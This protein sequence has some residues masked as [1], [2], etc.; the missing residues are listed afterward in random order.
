[1][2]RKLCKD[3]SLDYMLTLEK[4]SLLWLTT[5]IYHPFRISTEAALL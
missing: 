4:V 1:M 2:H 3:K 5:Q